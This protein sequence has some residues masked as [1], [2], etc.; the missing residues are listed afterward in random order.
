MKVKR[1]KHEIYRNFLEKIKDSTF[2]DNL[3]L[4]NLWIITIK[5]E[6]IKTLDAPVDKGMHINQKTNNHQRISLHEKKSIISSFN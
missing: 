5:Q 1:G 4:I 3:I 6:I 2:E